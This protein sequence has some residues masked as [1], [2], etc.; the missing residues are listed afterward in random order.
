MMQYPPRFHDGIE[1]NSL[2]SGDLLRSVANSD[3]RSDEKCDN[4]GLGYDSLPICIYPSR[5]ES[6]TDIIGDD[7][8][9]IGSTSIGGTI[10]K[11]KLQIHEGKK[12]SSHSA[13]K[14]VNSAAAAAPPSCRSNDNGVAAS[15]S[16]PL[17]LDKTPQRVTRQLSHDTTG[18][19]SFPRRQRV[20]RHL[21]NDGTV[22]GCDGEKSSVASPNAIRI[23]RPQPSRFAVP[24]GGNGN[25]AKMPV[26]AVGR[27]SSWRSTQSNGSNS[28]SCRGQLKSE[29]ANQPKQGLEKDDDDEF[30]T[31]ADTGF[32]CIID[33]LPKDLAAKLNCGRFGDDDDD[34]EKKGDVAQEGHEDNDDEQGRF[35]RRHRRREARDSLKLTDIMLPSFRRTG[36]GN[37]MGSRVSGAGS[38]CNPGTRRSSGYSTMMSSLS[39]A[40]SSMRSIIIFTSDMDDMDFNDDDDD[41]HHDNKIV[42]PKSGNSNGDG[43]GDSDDT[44][45]NGRLSSGATC[46]DIKPPR[47]PWRQKS[48]RS[49]VSKKSRNSSSGS[50]RDIHSAGKDTG[51]LDIAIRDETKITT[52]DKRVRRDSRPKRPWRQQ[53]GQNVMLDDFVPLSIQ[54]ATGI[55]CIAEVDHEFDASGHLRMSATSAATPFANSAMFRCSA[56]S[57]ETPLIAN[58][59]MFRLSATSADTLAVTSLRSSGSSSSREGEHELPFPVRRE[60]IQTA[61]SNHS[62]SVAGCSAASS[63]SAGEKARRFVCKAFSQGGKT[64]CNSASTAISTAAAK[65]SVPPDATLLEKKSFLRRQLKFP[66]QRMGQALRRAMASRHDGKSK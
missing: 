43:N 15:G 33:N 60:S 4:I 14:A 8:S 26:V 13:A 49:V 48:W 58:S 46:K 30:D 36:T 12:D 32:D 39:T 59:G 3:N 25:A 35:P 37:S 52:N 47:L 6:L 1:E 31:M 42:F 54:E 2:S 63:S 40:F 11:E 27:S 56:T 61:C 9:C 57:A 45:N 55:D 16:S 17:L 41:D 64:K 28:S 50:S 66:K 53:S 22:D 18:E 20:M 23:T 65:A 19:R 5:H 10:Q 21:S 34:D 51:G 62:K 44:P 24:I 29:S 38:V 7:V